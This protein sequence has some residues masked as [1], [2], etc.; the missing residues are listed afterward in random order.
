MII[1]SSEMRFFLGGGGA[2]GQRE[3]INPL[4]FYLATT[5]VFYLFVPMMT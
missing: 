5:S 4:E 2:E 3:E 1:F